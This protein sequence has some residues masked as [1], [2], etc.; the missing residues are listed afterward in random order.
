MQPKTYSWYK[1]NHPSNI[2]QKTA[3]LNYIVHQYTISMDT[4]SSSQDYTMPS[5]PAP[6]DTAT[7]QTYAAPRIIDL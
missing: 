1:H 6:T 3:L 2:I 7:K 4:L 5:T